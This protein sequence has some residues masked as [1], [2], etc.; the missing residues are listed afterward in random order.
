MPLDLGGP[1]RLDSADVPKEPLPRGWGRAE[2]PPLP[3]LADGASMLQ[4]G[5]FAPLSSPPGR[6][7]SGRFVTKPSTV[8]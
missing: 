1:A 8:T 4:E 6:R 3:G 5:I 7:S 2:A